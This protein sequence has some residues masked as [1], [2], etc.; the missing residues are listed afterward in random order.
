MID[1]SYAEIVPMKNRKFGFNIKNSIEKATFQAS[2]LEEMNQWIDLIKHNIHLTKSRP[3]NGMR[4][5]TPLDT[6]N[7]SMMN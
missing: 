5:G 4:F 3:M 1:L 6:L 2:S 7:L